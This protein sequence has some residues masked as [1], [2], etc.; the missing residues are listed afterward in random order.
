VSTKLAGRAHEISVGVASGFLGGVAPGSYR[1]GSHTD[2]WHCDPWGWRGWSS[3]WS[4]GGGWCWWSYPWYWGWYYPCW[5]WYSRPYYSSEICYYPVTTVVYAQPQVVYADPASEP[6]GEAVVTSQPA[7]KFAGQ[8][9]AGSLSIAAQRYL[10]LGDRAFREAR[11]T[12]A[13]QFYAKAVEF[14]PDQGALYLV[15]A[16][17]L[18]AA[19]DYHYGAFALRRAIEL[20]P[21][22]L[23]TQVDK[24]SF[25]AD[26]RQFDEHLSALE[27]YLSDH[28]ID[29]DARVVLALNY[30]FAGRANDAVRIFE[31][32]PPAADDLAGQRILERAKV[33]AALPAGR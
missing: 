14:A 21:A 5:W 4:F 10:E 1:G 22:L 32:Y 18:F 31:S 24:H 12:D 17:A 8:N 29:R 16:D 28:P 9:A 33:A 23:D 2:R 6:V 3:C 15:L 19:G 26:P 25:Y 27:R 7:G 30:L 20:E 13:V 11:Y